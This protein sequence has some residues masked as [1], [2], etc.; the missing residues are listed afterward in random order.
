MGHPKFMCNLG[1][2]GRRIR[3]YT[4]VDARV[5]IAS[6]ARAVALHDSWLGFEEVPGFAVLFPAGA[7]AGDVGIEAQAFAAYE[8]FDGQDV[9]DVE[10]QDVGD[11]DVDIFGGVDDFAFAVDAVDGLNVIAAGAEDFGAFELHAPK[12]GAGIEDAVVALAVSPG[13]GEVEAQGF[14]FEQEGGFGEFSGALGV[15]VDG[16]AVGCAGGWGWL[17]HGVW[18]PF[19]SRKMKKAQLLAAPLLVFI[20]IE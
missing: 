19:G 8:S 1:F 6:W 17:H 18:V 2:G 16:L 20:D 14:G 11:E 10:R 13:L 3:G 7:L 12:A 5:Y 15:A 9:P 4:S